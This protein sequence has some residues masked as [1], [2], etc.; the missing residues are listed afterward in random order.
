MTDLIPN[1]YDDMDDIDDNSM[2]LPPLDDEDD[3]FDDDYGDGFLENDRKSTVIYSRELDSK[4]SNYSGGSSG[5][6]V[7]NIRLFSL[8]A[9]ASAFCLSLTILCS[10]YLFK[11]DNTKKQQLD[12][13]RESL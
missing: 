4:S 3:E 7:S 12:N 13:R 11:W 5:K 6:L 10:L 8:V 9:W 2:P 1:F